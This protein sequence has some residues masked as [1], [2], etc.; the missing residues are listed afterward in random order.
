MIYDF[1]EDKNCSVMKDQ[2]MF[3]PDLLVAPVMD[4]GIKSRKVYLPENVNWIEAA[5]GKL[6]TGGCQVECQ[7]PLNVI[8]VFI[9]EG[10]NIPVYQ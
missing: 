8:P 9:R 5:T 10:K 2:Y 4:P 1:P 6:Y 3:G 7:T